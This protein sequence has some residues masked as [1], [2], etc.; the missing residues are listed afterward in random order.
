MEREVGLIRI[1]TEKEMQRLKR[2]ERIRSLEYNGW[3][4][5]IKRQGIPAYLTKGW[6]ESR[7]Q[8]IARHKL[9]S[10]RKR[11]NIGRRRE[12]TM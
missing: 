4:K 9:R 7:W 11:A 5:W 2:C 1:T 12:M 3:C 8:R 6:G 10:D